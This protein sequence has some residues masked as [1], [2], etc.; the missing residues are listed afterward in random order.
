MLKSQLKE[1]PI[2]ERLE[3]QNILND[4]QKRI[5]VISRAGNQRKKKHQ[6]RRSF[7]I[8]PYAFAK[9]LFMES[10]SGELDV[11]K[12]ELENHLRM[13]YPDDLNSI[14]ISPLRDL[15]KPQDLTVMFDDSGIK[16]KEV[17]DFIHKARTGSAPGMNRIP[18]KLYKNCPDIFRKLTVLLQQV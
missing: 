9:K 2:H 7:N 10:S 18:Y 8:N 15:P 3:L 5:L 1:A 6:T 12:V 13:T 14:P 4:I 11:L 16:L 17:Q